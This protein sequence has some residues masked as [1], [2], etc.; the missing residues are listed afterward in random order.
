MGTATTPAR[1][2]FPPFTRDSAIQKVRLAE[3]AWNTRDPAKVALAY[4]IDSHWRNRSEFI[5][6]RDEI[7]AFLSRKWAK[8]IDYRLIK[9]M[10]AFTG[11]RIAVRFAY[12]W[13]DDSDHCPG[14][15]RELESV[16]RGAGQVDEP[17][18]WSDADRLGRLGPYGPVGDRERGLRKAEAQPGR[19][20]DCQDAGPRALAYD[21]RRLARGRREGARVHRAVHND[22]GKNSVSRGELG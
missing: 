19:D 14:S 10:W 18:P 8:E 2:P 17:G 21:R 4:T 20:R 5:N 11:N 1:P 12:E 13:H 9:E 3:D 15:V 16:V 7:I 22:H 6:G